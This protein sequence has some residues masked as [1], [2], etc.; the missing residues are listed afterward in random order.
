MTSGLRLLTCCIALIVGAWQ[1]TG[2]L[3]AEDADSLLSDVFPPDPLAISSL[4]ESQPLPSTTGKAKPGPKDVIEGDSLITPAPQPRS[5][6]PQPSSPQPAARDELAFLVARAPNIFGH[7]FNVGGTLTVSDIEG[8]RTSDVPLAGACG[9]LS[10]AE[11]NNALPQDR[12]YFLYNHFQNA[13][14]AGQVPGGSPGSKFP[15]DRYVIGLEK[16]FRQGQWSVEMRMPFS[17]Q[18][19]YAAQGLSVDGGQFGNLAIIAKRIVRKTDMGAIS[20]GLGIDTPVGSD[21]GGEI[22][23]IRYAVHNEAVH[24]HPYVCLYVDAPSGAFCQGFLQVDVPLNGNSVDGEFAGNPVAFGAWSEQTLLHLDLALGRWLIRNREEGYVKALAAIVE[25]H[26]VPTLSDATSV[27]Q[28][29]GATQLTFGNLANR[30][31][32][33]DVTFGLH[34]ELP[35][36]TRCRVGCALPLTTG[37]S[38]AFDAELLVQV[39]R[40]F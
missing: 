38:R 37:D 4:L 13:L 31:D 12:A 36:D 11:N 16:V 27:S 25:F 32:M 30:V 34:A 9:R 39:E 28:T 21:V 24:L 22:N 20:A 40:C 18:M 23:G 1:S 2:A 3:A 14:V 10:V 8:T 17:G 19:N 15:V 26:Y 6:R 29:I 7:Y 35:R 5:P 33:A